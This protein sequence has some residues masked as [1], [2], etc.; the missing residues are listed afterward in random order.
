[1]RW[2]LLK[3]IT[4]LVPH[5]NATGLA[6]TDF[7]DELFQDHFPTHPV[8]PGV[9]LIEMCAQLA[10]RLVEIS[11]GANHGH[12]VFPVMTMVMEAKFRRFVPPRVTLELRAEL[13]S[14]R[15]E[16]A[17]CKAEVWWDNARQTS[18][19]LMFVFD[20]NGGANQRNLETLLAFERG[21]FLRLGLRGFPP[22]PVEV[23][24]AAEE[25]STWTPN[26]SA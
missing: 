3:Q 20:P 11:A 19:R 17:I 14:L 7:P 2:L 22:G 5:K 15:H 8:T 25:G 12:M 26:A 6:S 13:E 1:M 23:A 9:L 16:S 10:G 18:M 21:E 4:A 24:G